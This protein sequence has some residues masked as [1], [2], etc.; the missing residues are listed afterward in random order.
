MALHIVTEDR[1]TPARLLAGRAMVWGGLAL[2]LGV[3]ALQWLD[4]AGRIDA[5]F[6]DWR[7]TLYAFAAF[8]TLLCWSQVVRRGEMGKR[9]LFVLPAAIFVGAMVVFP[10]IFGIGIALSDWNLASPTGRQFNG[11]DNL[12]QAWNDPFY[13]NALLNMVWYIAAIAV[14]YVIAFGLALL[15]NAQIRGRKFFRVAFL[16]PLMLS[17]VA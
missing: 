11:L 3:A 10:L 2:L 15:L 8:A 13:L 12:R 1:I 16:L 5:G 17:P 7:P 6:R 9:A 4:Q 14:E